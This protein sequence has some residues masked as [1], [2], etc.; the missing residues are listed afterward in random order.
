MFRCPCCGY[1]T[2][3]EPESGTFEICQVDDDVQ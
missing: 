2:L 3:P 1:L